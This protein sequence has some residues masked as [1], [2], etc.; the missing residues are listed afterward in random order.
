MKFG[1]DWPSFLRRKRLK[2]VDYGLMT[3]GR[4]TK[5]ACNTISSPMSLKA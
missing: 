2:S 3:D 1:F 5:L 4:M